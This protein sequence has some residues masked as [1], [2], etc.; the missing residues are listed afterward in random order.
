MLDVAVKSYIIN[1]VKNYMKLI[2]RGNCDLREFSYS[3]ENIRKA[4][5]DSKSIEYAFVNGSIKNSDFSQCDGEWFYRNRLPVDMSNIRDG[6]LFGICKVLRPE[7]FSSLDWNFYLGFGTLLYYPGYEWLC[8]V[9]VRRTPSGFDVFVYS[10]IGFDYSKLICSKELMME[11]VQENS[12]IQ[13]LYHYVKGIHA[14]DDCIC[15]VDSCGCSEF[16]LGLKNCKSCIDMKVFSEK[17]SK[18]CGSYFVRPFERY[19]II[20]SKDV[21]EIQKVRYDSCKSIVIYG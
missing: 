2:Y 7:D 4:L 13:D 19:C 11:D 17:S 21:K 16:G 9:D 18:V 1:N 5:S 15:V 3:G 10:A 12:S 6:L 8:T 20:L 14:S